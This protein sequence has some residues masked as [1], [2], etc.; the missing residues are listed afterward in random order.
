MAVQMG[1]NQPTVMMER[2]LHYLNV[3]MVRTQL[4]LRKKMRR[5]MMERKV[6]RRKMMERKKARSHSLKIR[7]SKKRQLTR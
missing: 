3:L 5:K 7:R 6:R 2:S 1:R 4:H